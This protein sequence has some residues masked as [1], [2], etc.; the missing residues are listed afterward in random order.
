M[1]NKLVRDPRL[2]TL[3]GL[4]L[5]MITIN[6]LGSPLSLYT[7]QPF[8]FYSAAE[9]F[10][11][12]SGLVAGLVYS[13]YAQLGRG[14][15]WSKAFI[16][17]RDIYLVHILLVALL[18]VCVLLIQD[19][20]REKDLLEPFWGVFVEQ[21]PEL[22]FF[23]YATLLFHSS[24]LDILPMYALFLLAMPLVIEAL[25]K[26]RWLW[27]MSVSVG[28]WIAVQMGLRSE[29]VVGWLSNDLLL[30][31]TWGFEFLAWQLLFVM[32]MVAGAWRVIYPEQS[33]L[34]PRFWLWLLCVLIFLFLGFVHASGKWLQ[35]ADVEIWLLP[36]IIDWRDWVL[37]LNLRS[38]SQTKF[39]TPIRLLNFLVLVYLIARLG[40]RCPRC[41]TQS[42]LAWLGQ[43]SLSVFAWHVIIVFAMTPLGMGV[44]AWSRGR[45][46]LAYEWQV[47]L[48]LLV[49]ASLSLPAWLHE[50]HQQ[51]QKNKR[52]A[53]L[54]TF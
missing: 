4:M 13:Y 25:V 38:L 42:W 40:S 15:L 27:V 16:R 34:P 41:L 11:F 24:Y 50:R 31:K 10:V 53:S 8:G 19:W 54:G 51:H 3:R 2:D 30:L 47:A 33:A 44:A 37:S 48:T 26:K 49:V 20:L 29:Q 12:L 36:I 39:I 28:L 35:R 6:H 17:A 52:A 45:L 32:G 1:I 5:V 43:H 21:P 22:T 14:F 23:L 46:D 9:G 18:L 7:Y